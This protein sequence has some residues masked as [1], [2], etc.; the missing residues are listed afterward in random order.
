MIVD[1][2]GILVLAVLVAWGCKERRAEKV[3]PAP[4]AVTSQTQVEGTKV[5]LPDDYSPFSLVDGVDPAALEIP[6]Q[7]A[8]VP[9][10]I[11]LE[12]GDYE[13]PHTRAMEPIIGN[14]LERFPDMARYYLHNPLAG[15]KQGYVLALAASAAQRQGRFWEVHKLLFERG[16]DLDEDRLL[17]LARKAGLDVPLFL[18]DMKRGQIKEHLERNRALVAALNLWG[19]PVFLINGKVVMGAVGEEQLAKLIRTELESMDSLLKS[20]T[21]LAQ[22]HQ[23][24]A[25]AY[26]PY[27]TVLTKGVDWTK[28]SG[29]PLSVQLSGRYAVEVQGAPDLGPA[30][31]PVTMVEYIDLTCPFSKQAFEQATRLSEK[32]GDR[33]RVFFRINPA[34]A[35]KG[36]LDAALT[37]AYARRE[38]HLLDFVL[39]WFSQPPETP[40]RLAAACTGAGLKCPPATSLADEFMDSIHTLKTGAVPIEALGTPVVY[41][42]GVRRAGLQQ[43]D[44][45]EQLVDEQLNLAD[46]LLTKG[47]KPGLVYDFIISRASVLPLLA[48]A[49][50]TFPPLDDAFM[51]GDSKAPIKLL[52][53]WDYASPFCRNLWVHLENILR[54]ADGRIALFVKFLPRED[55]R[56]SVLAALGAACAGEKGR[57]PAFHAQLAGMEK[58]RFAQQALEQL[59]DQLD[60]DGEEFSTCMS[61]T[62]AETYL[63]VHREQARQ[64]GVKGAPALFANGRRIQTPAG[65]DFHSITAAI[66]QID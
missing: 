64:A 37:A 57:F 11:V 29:K 33:L 12:A 52:V 42:N 56:R 43:D 65:L 61:A 22:A 1:R 51:L 5:E 24:I 50:N 27:M 39:A 41:V 15:H 21:P 63:S 48:P 23:A 20:G 40:D 66:E 13:C 7:G 47:L 36:A 49:Q 30:V 26:Q 10:V 28:G 8:P 32:L 53:F 2:Y 55:D 35:A 3:G 62:A 4:D 18:K 45:L 54:S 31:A 16:P 9:K 6:R 14:L 58:E 25:A 46:A 19:T 44:A 59:A 38:G 17:A 60:L 34:L